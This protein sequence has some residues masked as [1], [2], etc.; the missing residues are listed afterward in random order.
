MFKT[1]IFH[2]KP[3]DDEKQKFPNKYV[4]IEMRTNK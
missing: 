3:F 2:Q 4:L 1:K